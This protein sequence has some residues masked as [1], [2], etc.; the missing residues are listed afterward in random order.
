MQRRR[1]GTGARQGALEHRTAAL[2][3]ILQP[4]PVQD[5]EPATAR[6]DQASLLESG[7]RNGD[8]AA[9]H[10]ED[11]RERFV[12]DSHLV[13]VDPLMRHHQPARASLG[14]ASPG[15]AGGG[16]HH[17]G[18]QGLN[19]AGAGR[20]QSRAPL[21]GPAQV[22]AGDAQRRAGDVH[23]NPAARSMAHIHQREITDHAFTAD[24]G[25]LHACLTIQRFGD[26]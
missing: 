11:L 18:E 1:G 12:G 4:G 22:A 6:P 23:E 3:N 21:N 20:A 25:N 16:L 2:G 8:A 14:K 19:E 17:L 13:P 26:D 5:D 9:A 15:V 24:H 7:R 10:A